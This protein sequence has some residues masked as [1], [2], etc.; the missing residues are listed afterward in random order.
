MQAQQACGRACSRWPAGH[1]RGSEKPMLRAEATTDWLLNSHSQAKEPSPAARSGIA[2]GAARATLHPS[3]VMA[4]TAQR[5]RTCHFG[6][7][8]RAMSGSAAAATN[9]H[10]SHSSSGLATCTAGAGGGAEAHQEGVA[11]RV[12]GEPPSGNSARPER[13]R[14]TQRDLLDGSSAGGRLGRGVLSQP[15]ARVSTSG[16]S[17]AARTCHLGS[18]RVT[19]P[20]MLTALATASTNAAPSAPVGGMARAR[21]RWRWRAAAAAP[22]RG[23]KRLGGANYLGAVGLPTAA[24][25]MP[26]GRRQPGLPVAGPRACVKGSRVFTAAGA[27]GHAGDAGRAT[28]GRREDGGR[29]QQGGSRPMHRRCEYRADRSQGGRHGARRLFSGLPSLTG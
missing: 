3:L 8:K 29:R 24:A 13:C 18:T 1:L 14:W 4:A 11:R 9:M 26:L 25:N 17:R 21:G 28:T 2:N 7:A 19:A 16:G 22:P 12:C 15:K 10:V 5:R 23:A 20:T 27:A 6:A